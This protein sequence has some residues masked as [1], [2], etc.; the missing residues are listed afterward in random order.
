MYS[1]GLEYGAS[2]L[3]TPGMNRAGN[4][5]VGE[6]TTGGEDKV[7]LCVWLTVLNVGSGDPTSA[8]SGVR[9]TCVPSPYPPLLSSWCSLGMVRGRRQAKEKE[10]RAKGGRSKVSE[11]S[12]VSTQR[13]FRLMLESIFLNVPQL[14]IIS[15]KYVKHTTIPYYLYH[16]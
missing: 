15:R 10:N 3:T 8:S 14:V 9:W 11:V 16:V 1:Q 13:M 5:K 12:I 7:F 6:V 4:P 2:G